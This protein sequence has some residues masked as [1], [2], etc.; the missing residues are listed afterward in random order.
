M[1]GNKYIDRASELFDLTII[2]NPCHR[3]VLECREVPARS[4][5]IIHGHECIC[6]DSRSRAAPDDVT[7]WP[8]TLVKVRF[9]EDGAVLLVP[10][11]TQGAAALDGLGDGRVGGQHLRVGNV[12]AVLVLKGRIGACTESELLSSCRAGTEPTLPSRD[13]ASAIAQREGGPFDVGRAE[14]VQEVRLAGDHGVVEVG[15]TQLPHIELRIKVLASM[16]QTRG[17]DGLAVSW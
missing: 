6:G 3:V 9:H 5:I 10:G 2:K 14:A 13:A 8:D 7:I 4:E 11:P 16:P 15:V 12:D 1:L 17:I